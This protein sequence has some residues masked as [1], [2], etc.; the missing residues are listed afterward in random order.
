MPASDA[1]ITER[2]VVL[3]DGR[4]ISLSPDRKKAE[5]IARHFRRLQPAAAIVVRDRAGDRSEQV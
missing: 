3:R 5:Q 4:T 1:A 2:F